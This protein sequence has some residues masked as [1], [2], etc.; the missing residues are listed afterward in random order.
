M[1]PDVRHD[2]SIYHRFSIV[3]PKLITPA[4]G[5]DLTV[6]EGFSRISGRSFFV[7]IVSGCLHLRRL[8]GL[9]G[10]GYLESA[11]AAVQVR[12]QVLTQFSRIV[13]CA[14]DEAR[15]ATPQQWCSHEVYAGVIDD[16]TTVANATL[17]V[18][19]WQIQPGMVGAIPGCPQDGFDIAF[20]QVHQ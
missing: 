15:F 16:T 3:F 5:K 11:E 17:V 2:K 19:H 9:G 14:M 4:A 13:G 20:L 7:S 18:E 6:A 12:N 8:S 10:G 1:Y